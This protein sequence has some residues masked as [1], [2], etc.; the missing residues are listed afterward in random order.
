MS[1]GLPLADAEPQSEELGAKT[2][3]LAKAAR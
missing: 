1:K 2:R 3:E